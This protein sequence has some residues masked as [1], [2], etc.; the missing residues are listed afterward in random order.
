[1]AEAEADD[2]ELER[3]EEADRKYR[4]GDY[5]DMMAYEKEDMGDKVVHI[6]WRRG[7]ACIFDVQ[8]TDSDAARHRGDPTAKVLEKGGKEK[9]NIIRRSAGP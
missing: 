7:T 8:V 2:E 4:Q 6:F 9:E 5:K 1:M 3:Q